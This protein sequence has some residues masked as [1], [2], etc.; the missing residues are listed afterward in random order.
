MHMYAA[1]TLAYFLAILEALPFTWYPMLR[2]S[3]GTHLPS[4]ALLCHPI[5][6]SLFREDFFLQG[7]S[8]DALFPR[9]RS[10][11]S[12]MGRRKVCNDAP[13]C[14]CRRLKRFRTSFQD[15]E[16]IF[17]A[18]NAVPITSFASQL[19]SI[20]SQRSHVYVD[21]PSSTA[22]RRSTTASLLKYLTAS[23]KGSLDSVADAIPSSKRVALG[24]EVAKL[25][26]VKSEAEQ[27]IMHQAATIS[28]RAHAK[29][30]RFTEPGKTES[31]L[32]AHFEYTC[33]LNGAQRPAYVPVV[34]SGANA[35]VI[36]YTSNNQ[37]VDEGE[38]VLIDAGC[39]FKCV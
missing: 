26:H 24:P 8:H 18:D 39:E 3:F 36:H 15:V 9:N 6:N 10:C 31:A 25:R 14:N 1:T 27:A 23:V 30:M 7:L 22:T 35:L 29:T 37:V 2:P 11:Q 21:I 5:T 34:G 28:G 20:L 13:F 4:A 17:G 38:M 32:A 19:R 33:A 16:K 12:Q